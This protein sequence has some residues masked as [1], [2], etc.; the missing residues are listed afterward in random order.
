MNNKNKHMAM[1]STLLLFFS[2]GAMSQEYQSVEG[3]WVSEEGNAVIKIYQCESDNICGDIVWL[4][5]STYSEGDE[6][7][8]PEHKSGTLQLDE[9]NPIES[10]QSRPVEGM[11][12]LKGF[13]QTSEKR[14]T[15]GSIYNPKNGK[16]YHC[17]L[18]LENDGDILKIR[19][20]MGFV[21]I[22]STTRWVRK[23]E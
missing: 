20:F 23:L 4:K 13:V 17:I 5:N 19:G 11:T 18:K 7:E 16:S 14:W 12:I 22:G 3:D 9:K 10:L 1:I 8:N 2:F 15:R 6:L 21:W